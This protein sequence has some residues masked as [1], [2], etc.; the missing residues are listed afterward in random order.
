[1]EAVELVLSGRVQGV[2]LRPFVAR[3][4]DRL[5][6]VGHVSNI[7][8]GVTIL[9]EGSVEAIASFQE[10]LV[11]DLP[12]LVQLQRCE[13]RRVEPKGLSGFRV[14]TTQDRGE[15]DGESAGVDT[16]LRSTALSAHIPVDLVLCDQC[17][18]EVCGDGRRANYPFTSCTACGP[19]YSIIEHMP[20]ERAWTTMARFPLCP[21]C[22]DEY[23][24]PKDRRLHA[25]TIA[26]PACGP[27][28]WLRD[29]QGAVLDASNP[30][31]TAVAA[32]RHGRILAVRG[33]GGYQLL[34]DATSKTAVARLRQRKGRL[35]K[36]LAVM[37]ASADDAAELVE[38]NDGERATLCSPAGP[39]V[40]ARRRLSTRSG[41]AIAEAVPNGFSQLGV[42]LPTTP[43]HLLLLQ[44]VEVPLIC[45]SG[46]VEGEPL[47]RDADQAISQLGDVADVFLE[48][49]R[50]IHN[51]IDD[52]VVQV[53]AGRVCPLRAARGLAPLPLPL[54]CDHPLLAV[55]GDQKNAVAVSNGSQAVLGPHIGDLN[56]LP[57][58]ARFEQQVTRLADLYGVDLNEATL[59]SDLHPGYY[60][61]DWVAR[62]AG[63]SR[64]V[65]VQHHHA[66]VIA[67]LLSQSDVDWTSPVLGV[68][69]DGTGYGLDGAVWGGEFL[70]VAGTSCHRWGHLREFLLP[71]NELAIRQ[72]WRTSVALVRDAL[73]D[74]AA[75][76]LPFA[77]G[78]LSQVLTLLSK[79]PRLSPVTTSAGRL[80]DGV[81]GLILGCEQT[82]F[83][84]E[85]AM[86]LEAACDP[87]AEGEY[88]LDASAATGTL[89]WRPLIRQLWSDCQ[90]RRTAPGVMA[91]RFHRG[92]AN[93]ILQMCR[94]CPDVP[95][96]LAGGVFQN[97][98]LVELLVER[99]ADTGRKVIVPGPIPVNDGG[100]AAGQLAI[101]SG[102]LQECS[103]ADRL[104]TI[105]STSSGE[106]S[107]HPCA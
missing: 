74:A 44:Q 81:A 4:A 107:C 43:L 18:A 50:P 86:R 39:I 11:Q 64:R 49:D 97:R 62:R 8:A 40:L 92:L 20:Y 68:A 83:E 19:R 52:S 75:A 45:T 12:E 35:G 84:G 69:F 79:G 46:N 71:G 30:L 15:D 36:P 23:Q 5:G 1:M 95:I 27:R 2:G 66:H 96:V 60:S 38:L 6:L 16:P 55:G 105:A 77:N 37:V 53:I 72:P 29:A 57:T 80:F 42:M 31:R 91:M 78:Q 104:R 47:V 93:G 56:S 102:L 87:A 82:D 85:A 33:L 63:P 14:T 101:A 103:A 22:R 32:L 24:S 58:R 99:F 73:G 76:T 70:R 98:I 34:V 9:V 67:A 25:Q 100:L 41:S 26:C 94:Q 48:H 59:V 21:A 90:Q 88:V 65:L 13:T 89:D 28:A 61:H 54:G 7:T 106:A 51:P 17:A 3:L 10:A